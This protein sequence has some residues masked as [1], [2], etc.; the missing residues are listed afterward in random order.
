[1]AE[2][3]DITSKQRKKILSF[4]LK[5]FIPSWK[6]YLKTPLNPVPPPL[7]KVANAN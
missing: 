3:S 5:S 4:E 2:E 6:Y 1:M 7:P